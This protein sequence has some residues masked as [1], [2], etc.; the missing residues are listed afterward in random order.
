MI[1]SLTLNFGDPGLGT[2]SAFLRLAAEGLAPPASLGEGEDTQ[3]DPCGDR[4]GN[5][6]SNDSNRT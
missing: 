6:V 2:G 5:W 3:E 4:S 1:A